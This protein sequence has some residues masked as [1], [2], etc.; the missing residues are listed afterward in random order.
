MLSYSPIHFSD[1][2]Y[3]LHHIYHFS[4]TLPKCRNDN[5]WNLECM[6]FGMECYPREVMCG[7]SYALFY[8]ELR[9][10]RYES[11]TVEGG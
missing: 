11:H 8:G 6:R 5:T 4:V 2:P 9:M 1:I 3:H 10:L 7:D